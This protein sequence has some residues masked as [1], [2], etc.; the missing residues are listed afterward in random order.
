MGGW[1]DGVM[2]LRVRGVWRGEYRVCRV[3]DSIEPQAQ[4]A[5]RERERVVST[6]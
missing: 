2:G 3:F 1:V 4:R 5:P 6:F